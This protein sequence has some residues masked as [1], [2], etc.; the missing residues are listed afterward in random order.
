MLKM[1]LAYSG[2]LDTS[3]MI[4][5][6]KENYKGAYVITVTVD[7]GQKENLGAIKQKA[8]NSGASEAYV[9]DARREFVIDYLTPLIKSGAIYE[10]QYVLGTISRPIIAKKLVDVALK[11]QAEIIVHGATG[12]GNDQVRF[13]YT[14]N[15]MAPHLRVISPWRH[16]EIKSRKQAIDYAHAHGVEVPNTPDSPYSRDQNLWYL[17]HEGGVLEDINR[18][19]PDDILMTTKSLQD[20]QE[21]YE[22]I[23]IGFEKGVVV[24]VNEKTC[25]PVDILYSLS[26][27]GGRHGIGVA[28]IIESRLIGMKIRGVYES[29]AASIIYKAHHMLETACLDRE[30]LDI[31][32]SLRSRYANIVYDG[33]WFSQS[34]EALDAFFDLTQKNVTGNVKLRLYKGNISFMGIESCNTLYKHEFAT[35]DEDDVYTQSDAEGFIKIFSLP[36]KIYGLVH[37]KEEDK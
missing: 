1:V 20:A 37:K 24:S 36:A 27:I 9:I 10:D 6:I 14:I 29:P 17:S 33:K 34:R 22:D 18:P 12:K 21:D 26:E 8:I 23:K 25:D 32:I 11:N 30:L 16:W 13:E 4:P 5:W 15:A 31:K 7:V 28:D 19:F 2:G 35:F 3:V